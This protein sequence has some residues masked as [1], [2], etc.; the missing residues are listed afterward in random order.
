MWP[1]YTANDK[2]PGSHSGDPGFVPRVIHVGCMIA[3]GTGT[4]FSPISSGLPCQYH[5]TAAAY[6]HCFMWATV[7]RA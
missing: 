3:K 4:G 5:S 7:G 1:C 2:S 6:S